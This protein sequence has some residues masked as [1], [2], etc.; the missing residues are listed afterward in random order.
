MGTCPCPGLL[1]RYR[2]TRG[3]DGV[4]GGR[5]AANEGDNGVAQGPQRGGRRRRGRD[6][7]QR[8]ASD[9]AVAVDRNG[10][11]RT[12]GGGRNAHVTS[13]HRRHGSRYPA[14]TADRR[15]PQAVEEDSASRTPLEDPAARSNETQWAPMN[16]HS[17]REEHDMFD[18][19]HEVARQ[20]NEELQREVQHRSRRARR[21]RN[22]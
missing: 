20:R 22:Q 18:L 15:R 17:L 3:D 16:A 10:E 4:A 7:A 1:P 19:M 11:R 14:G 21:G 9:I 13:H 6:P 8:S 5:A 12:Q 2:S